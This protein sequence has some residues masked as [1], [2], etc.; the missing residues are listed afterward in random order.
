[1][2]D[3]YG[4]KAFDLWFL[5]CVPYFL[6]AHPISTFASANIL[7]TNQATSTVWHERTKNMGKTPDTKGMRKSES[8]RLKR[9]ERHK[10]DRIDRIGK[11]LAEKLDA[12]G[13][14]LILTR[15][16]A[17]H[18]VLKV[19]ADKDLPFW[20]NGNAESNKPAAGWAA[21][22]HRGKNGKWIFG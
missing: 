9:I 21:K 19:R 7:F 20:G 3:P 5:N 17:K 18:P 10:Q 4:S 13:K 15:E 16:A 8:A 6:A 12:K 1:M 14:L 11:E 22:G 2:S